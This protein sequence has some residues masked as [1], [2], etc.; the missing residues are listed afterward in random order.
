MNSK[1]KIF[2]HLLIVLPILLLMGFYSTIGISSNNGIILFNEAIAQPVP[3]SNTIEILST[4]SYVDDIG[5]FHLV[6]EVNNTSF[7]PQTNVIVGALLYNLTTNELVGNYSAFTSLE[8]LRS[9]ELSPFHIVVDD[10]QTIGNFDFIDFFT[11]SQDG[12]AKPSNLILNVTNR[13]VDEFGNPHIAGNVVNQNNFPE[14]FVNL[15][16]TYYDN[17]SLGVIGTETF[18]V[19]LGNISQGQLAWF[20]LSLVDNMT[21]NKAQ[22]FVLSVE[23][24]TSSMD[25]PLN[26]KRPLLTETGTIGN[27]AT[28]SLFGEPVL[29][30][31]QGFF[32]NNNDD[33]N[34]QGF[35]PSSSS[36]SNT[37]S[38]S[39]NSPST[40]ESEDLDIEIEVA[41]KVISPGF[42]QRYVVTVNDADT[43]NSIE[44]AIVDGK[45]MYASNSVENN[46]SFENKITNE[47]GKVEHNWKI[48]NAAKQ[49]LF[50]IMVD[51]Q[52]DGYKSGS[53]QTNFE[54]IINNSTENNNENNNNQ[55][56]DANA[57][58]INNGTSS[59]SDN[60]D[61]T[62]SD[63]DADSD[64]RDDQQSQ[65]GNT[66]SSTEDNTDQKSSDPS[67]NDNNNDNNSNGSDNE[68]N[69]NGNTD[70]N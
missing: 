44:G 70:E 21:K 34:G 12:Q 52:A 50:Q 67:D 33:D 59:E 63:E 25:Y 1:P 68:G 13:Y 3:Q 58:P 30:I 56:D 11:N 19:D 15:I 14:S 55:T 41:E 2:F 40:S 8:V 37:G 42:D 18:G 69:G 20:D 45:V 49:G 31:D 60:Q 35:S 47:E 65:D 36:N 64:S 54:V 32:N 17:S 53:A 9:G 10:V 57:N 51:V 62:N 43:G 29:D 39:N 24:N 22:F 16:A 5:N 27:S 66:S 61:S 23:S 6:G 48:S 28:S 46:G 4:S 26:L 38:T 7:Q